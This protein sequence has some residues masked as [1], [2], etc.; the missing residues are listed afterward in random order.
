MKTDA[1]YCNADCYA[2]YGVSLSRYSLCRF[3]ECRYAPCRHAECHGTVNVN[4]AS[5]I[6][7]TPYGDP[8]SVCSAHGSLFYYNRKLQS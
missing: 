6:L 7:K 2:G 5:V 3:S 4:I 1:V 8:G